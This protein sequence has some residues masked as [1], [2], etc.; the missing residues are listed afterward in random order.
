M[1]KDFSA[2]SPWRRLLGRM[3]VRR[4]L[5]AYRRAG[6]MKG[7]PRTI[8]RVDPHALAVERVDGVLLALAENRFARAEAHLRRLRELVERLHQ[9]GMVHLDLRGKSNVLLR[10]DGELVV[11]DMAAALWFRPGSLAHRLLFRWFAMADETALL[12]WKAR[13]APDLLTDEEEALLMRYRFFRSLWVLNRRHAR[14]APAK[15]GGS[16]IAVPLRNRPGESTRAAGEHE[17]RAEGEVA[18]HGT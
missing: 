10:P 14:P 9:R 7:L 1:V 18:G 11:V 17:G 16:G 6:E 4:E 13:L 8:G 5:R 3:Q 2:K 12:K 15:P